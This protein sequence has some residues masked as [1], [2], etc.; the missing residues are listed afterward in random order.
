M[1]APRMKMSTSQ[2]TP[3]GL[4]N[5]LHVVEMYSPPRVTLEARKFG[6]KAGEALDLT[7]GWDFTRRY[8][9]E[10]AEKYIEVEKPLVLIGSP[11]CTPFSQL[12]S[13]NPVTEKSKRKW[14]EGVEHIKL[15]VK[16]YKKQV[17]EGRVF[18]HEQPAHAKSWVIPEIKMMMA[19]AGVTVVEVDQCMYGLRT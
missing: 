8:H 16:L 15:L 7:N 6:L 17:G 19:E 11:P 10:R 13:L 3:K 18:L 2:D 14:K 12:Q 1:L 9:Q 4:I 5:Q